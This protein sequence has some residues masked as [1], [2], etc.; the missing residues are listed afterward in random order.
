MTKMSHTP[1]APNT[2][3]I[4]LQLLRS[5]S[6]SLASSLLLLVT[7]CLVPV[8]PPVLDAGGLTTNHPPAITPEL[9]SPPEGIVVLNAN[10]SEHAFSLGAIYEQDRDDLLYVRW[11]LDYDEEDHPSFAQDGL[12]QSAGVSSL[13]PGPTF[14][15]QPGSARQFPNG[16]RIGPETEGHRLEV[17]VSDRNFVPG[18]SLPNQT[19]PSE[20]Q[21]DRAWWQLQFVDD[22]DCDDGNAP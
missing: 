11:F 9:L 1:A 8:S 22:V 7:G 18:G 2:K 19:V 12:V 3:L 6:A 14:L 16:L 15:L 13:R 5:G 10:C 4:K 20:A 21:T 17:L